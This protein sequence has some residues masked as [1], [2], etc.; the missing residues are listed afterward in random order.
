MLLVVSAVP[1]FAASPEETLE[2]SPA[3]TSASEAEPALLPDEASLAEAVA[4]EEEK[5]VEREEWRASPEATSEREDSEYAYTDLT[6]S[7]EEELLRASF[8]PRLEQLDS[9]PARL[10]SDVQLDQ[11]FSPNEA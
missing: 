3:A 7:E 2:A 10:L 4:Q 1:V 6:A 8:A 11:V 9:D 5:E